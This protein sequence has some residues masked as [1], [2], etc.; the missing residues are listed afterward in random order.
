MYLVAI[1]TSFTV[2]SQLLR[3]AFFI[4]PQFTPNDMARPTRD[5]TSFLSPNRDRI[6]YFHQIVHEQSTPRGLQREVRV[7][8]LYTCS[9]PA[10]YLVVADDAH[11]LR[12]RRR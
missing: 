10:S 12:K 2:S 1:T 4:Y 5:C 3:H 8:P 9:R 11:G 7:S 6:S